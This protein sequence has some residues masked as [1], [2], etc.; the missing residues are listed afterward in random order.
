M[1][2][3]SLITPTD[4]GIASRSLGK[5]AGGSMTLDRNAAMRALEKLAVEVGVTDHLRLADGVI[6]IAVNNMCGGVRT[7]S[8]ERGHDPR[9]F[10]L[11]ALGGAGAMHAIPI[12]EELAISSVLV[13]AN[14]GTGS[15]FGLL[16]TDLQHDYVRTYVTPIR[17][18]DP[19]RIRSLLDDM[20]Q[21]GRRA[22]T[23]EGIASQ[24]MALAYVANLRYAGQS[25]QI[26]VA[27][28]LGGSL[29]DTEA[30]FHRAYHGVYGYS[31]TD[32]V[33]ELVY[34]RVLASAK[35]AKPQ[36]MSPARAGAGARPF[37]RLPVY[38]DGRLSDTPIYRH[39]DLPAEACIVGPAIIEERGT[40]TV[41]F[42]GW[43]AALDSA[44]NLRMRKQ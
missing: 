36:V 24:D 20:E 10:T 1:A 11:V 17:S 23:S 22:L 26:N 31:R 41:V 6:R 29:E 37:E 25:W 43:T 7:L 15:A 40:T 8:V 42:A 9:E 14:A 5:A 21:Q 12:A 3:A 44:G 4:Q 34:L 18:A 32:M 30:A 38:F 16:C 33:V 28:T 27:I 19:A 35:I 2:L 39:E 13:P